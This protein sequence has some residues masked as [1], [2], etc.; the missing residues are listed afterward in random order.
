MRAFKLVPVCLF[1]FFAFTQVISLTMISKSYAWT[2]CG[3][4]CNRLGC[5]CPGQCGCTPYQCRNNDADDFHTFTTAVANSDATNSVVQVRQIGECVR[6]SWALRVLGE[7]ANSL[8]V[9]SVGTDLETQSEQYTPD[10]AS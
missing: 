1:A 3:C 7:A 6:R 8:R 2:C 10:A 4:N 5:C 9:E